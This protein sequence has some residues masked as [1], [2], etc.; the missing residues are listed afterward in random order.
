MAEIGIIML[1]FEVGLEADVKRLVRTGLKS[2]VVAIAGLVL[3]LVLGFALGY[4]VFGLS[5]LVSL[6]IGGTLTATSIGIT[7][8][9][10]L[11]L[12][13]SR[14]SKG[15]LYWVLPFWTTSWAWCC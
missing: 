11:I 4:W 5:L 6:F 9:V 12:N 8:R 15:K 7:V 14:H 10:F 2:F 13:A 1:L 3:P